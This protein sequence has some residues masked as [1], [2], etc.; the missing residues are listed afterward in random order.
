[1]IEQ[2]PWIQFPRHLNPPTIRSLSL[3]F[4]LQ[5][6]SERIEQVQRLEELQG[7][8]PA[9]LGGNF[10]EEA[11]ELISFFSLNKTYPSASIFP[12][13]LCFYCDILLQASRI[14]DSP[15]LDELNRMSMF[16]LETR[17]SL[18]PEMEGLNASFFQE[19]R[20]K[21]SSI[22]SLLLPFLYEARSDENVLVKL[23]ELRNVL[24]CAL[25]LGT[26]ESVLRSFFPGGHAHLRTLIFEGLTRRSFTHFLSEKEPLID[27]IEWESVCLTKS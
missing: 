4:I 24:E 23:L 26:I 13:K 11:L 8:S 19:F 5:E 22:F 7:K 6:F 17:S 18:Y 27:A 16:I 3:L 9:L 2:D 21:I 20:G 25:G 12:N 14:G 1:M 10:R 15:L